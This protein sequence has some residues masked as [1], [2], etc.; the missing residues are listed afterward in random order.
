MAKTALKKAAEYEQYFQELGNKPEPK[1]FDT[2]KDVFM[3]AVTL[4]FCKGKRVAFQKSGGD[5]ISLRFF[6]DEDESIFNIIALTDTGEMSILL[7]D[8]EYREKK[9]KIV[10]E[11]ANGG[12]I[13]M[14]EEFCKP[15]VDEGAF[16]RFVE[17][18]EDT[19]GEQQK[20]SL[21][22]ILQKAMESI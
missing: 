21:E 15:I 8:D 1:I 9:Y 6:R 12:M 5:D 17:T 19:S 4:G 11:Y 18:F 7:P 13:I 20:T 2:M 10:E 14:A 22:D 16:R 3:F